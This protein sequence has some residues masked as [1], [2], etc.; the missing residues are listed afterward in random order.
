MNITEVSQQTGLSI[1]T[2]RFYEREGLLDPITRKSNGH[3][4]FSPKDL[5]WLTLFARLR[6]TGMPLKDMRHYVDL[7]RAG[8]S[9]FSERR[10]MLVTHQARLD[11][12]QQKLDACRTLIDH[13]IETYLELERTAAK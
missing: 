2:I 9:T 3:R 5:R 8:D 11:E 6:E 13:K 12:Q 7:A 1:D 4:A 10:Q